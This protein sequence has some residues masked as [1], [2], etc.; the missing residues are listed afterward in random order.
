MSHHCSLVSH[1]CSLW[2]TTAPCFA[3]NITILT[4]PLGIRWHPQ[5]CLV[6]IP[7]AVWNY[8]LMFMLLSLE[9]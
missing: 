7:A 9:D 1:H 4:I 6:A 2:A 5:C 3:P 8:S